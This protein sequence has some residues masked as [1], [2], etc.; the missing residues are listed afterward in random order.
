MTPRELFDIAAQ[1]WFVCAALTILSGQLWLGIRPYVVR[2]RNA[3]H[4]VWRT[5]YLFQGKLVGAGWTKVH[6]GLD[7]VGTRQRAQGYANYCNATCGGG[8]Y[9][10][11]RYR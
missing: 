11:K 4:G 5:G 6:G 2:W 8:P 10:V 3:K 9:K 1:A 7:Y